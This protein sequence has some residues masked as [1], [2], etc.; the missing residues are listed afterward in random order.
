MWIIQ[1]ADHKESG[2]LLVA[3]SGVLN[4]ISRAKIELNIYV[5]PASDS[6]RFL[7]ILFV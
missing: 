7:W 1:S 5:G 3:A 6:D 4:A 2:D